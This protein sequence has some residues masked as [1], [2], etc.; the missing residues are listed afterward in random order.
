MTNLLDK[1]SSVGVLFHLKRVGD[2]PAHSND[3]VQLDMGEAVEAY[4]YSCLMVPSNIGV[5]V[6][7]YL[8]IFPH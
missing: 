3:I 4:K 2:P 5:E 1:S 6:S 8:R 7:S